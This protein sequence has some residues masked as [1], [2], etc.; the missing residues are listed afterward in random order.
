MRLFSELVDCELSELLRLLSAEVLPAGERA[1]L[2]LVQAQHGAEA[3][4]A[5]SGSHG[6]PVHLRSSTSR[7]LRSSTDQTQVLYLEYDTF[8][9]WRY[10]DG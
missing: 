3:G 2:C 7:L 6:L 9:V 8:N 1:Q 10:A 4:P 5:L